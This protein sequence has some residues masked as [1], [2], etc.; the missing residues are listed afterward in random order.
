VCVFILVTLLVAIMR[1]SSEQGWHY[2]SPW[3]VARCLAYPHAKYFIRPTTLFRTPASF[4]SIG[5]IT[6][7]GAYHNT[8]APHLHVFDALRVASHTETNTREVMKAVFLTLLVCLVVVIPGYLMLIHYYGFDRR[9][10][11]DNWHNFYSYTAPHH[12]MAYSSIP[13]FF[14]R[15]K[16]WYTIP[17]GVA[18]I[19]VVMYLRRERV[20]FP[21]SPVGIVIAAARTY[22]ANYST[23]VIW[24]PIVIVLV[25]KRVIYRWFGVGF[26][27][28]KVIPVVM[29]LMMG[30]MTGMFIYKLIFASMGRGFLRP[31]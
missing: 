19:G 8:F 17:A 4:M 5:H 18:I 16:P 25:V 2:H 10:T 27:K 6:Q 11:S 24:L 31:Y 26:F 7:F 12:G 30:M 14:R 15:M 9:A 21:L 3:S 29:F 22:F 13:G 28:Q 23:S 20:R 1:Q